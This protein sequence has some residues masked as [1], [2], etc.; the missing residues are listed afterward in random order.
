MWV[1]LVETRQPDI[2]LS[3]GPGVLKSEASKEQAVAED[4][5]RL[6]DASRSKTQQPQMVVD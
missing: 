5:R 2:L 4:Q 6:D 1:R 3:N